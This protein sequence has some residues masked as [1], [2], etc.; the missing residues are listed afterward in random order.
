LMHLQQRLLCLNGRARPPLPPDKCNLGTL[1]W[2]SSRTISDESST[3]HLPQLLQ[4]LMEMAAELVFWWMLPTG[5]SE[6]SV[7][8]NSRINHTWLWIAL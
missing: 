4:S 2:G 3:S 7:R 1:V 6:S 5:Q 8:R